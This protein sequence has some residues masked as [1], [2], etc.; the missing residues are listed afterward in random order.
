MGYRA[1]VC[2]PAWVVGRRFDA[3]DEGGLVIRLDRTRAH[4]VLDPGALDPGVEVIADLLGIVGV[5][6]AAQ[7]RRDLSGLHRVN[8]RAN[9]RLVDVSQVRLSPKNDVG[10]V[11][12]LC[13]APPV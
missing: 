12:H 13:Q 9:E 10:G 5:Q 3:Q 2:E 6:L 1:V 11:L 4:M 7:E 8:R